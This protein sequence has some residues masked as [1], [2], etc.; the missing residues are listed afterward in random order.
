MICVLADSVAIEVCFKENAEAWNLFTGVLE[1]SW[2]GEV[3][4]TSARIGSVL[5]GPHWNTTNTS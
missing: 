1:L 5:L 3:C 2:L 4:P